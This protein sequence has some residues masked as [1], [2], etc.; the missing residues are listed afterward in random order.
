M[1]KICYFV[2][3]DWYFHLH[4]LERAK[5]V[6]EQEYEVHVITHFVNEEIKADLINLGFICHHVGMNAQSFNPFNL[7]TSFYT[8]HKLIK[9]INPDILHCITIKPTLIGGLIAKKY[10]K[11][12][13]LSFVG[14]GRV[15]MDNY[16]LMAPLQK[17]I[18]KL[19]K[20]ICS[21]NKCI[22]MFE[23]EHDRRRLTKLLNLDKNKTVVVDGAGIN[24]NIY[25]Y[26]QENTTEK[27]VVLFASRLLWNKGIGDLVA[28]KKKLAEKNID[29]ELK[30]AGIIVDNDSDAVPM[31]FINKWQRDGLIT[32]LGQ[33]QD[34]YSLIKEC[35]IVALPSVYAE[36]IPRILLEACSVGRSCIAYNVGG[37]DSLIIDKVNGILIDK[38]DVKSLTDNIEYLLQAP[39]VRIKM[40]MQGR[41]RIEKKFTTEH[42]SRIT[43]AVYRSLLS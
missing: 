11:A 17:I 12:A 7:L 21:N 5:K 20:I 10:N 4:W 3:S 41:S 38:G 9:K 18:L 31:S 23:H 28:V 33:T 24:H 32:W 22:L 40:G 39:E 1:K 36:G 15:F 37:C 6:Q 13:V 30:V 25:K 16:T 35:N 26:S 42:I 2:N 14:L 34:V 19:Y 27:P 29:F 8:S 43:L